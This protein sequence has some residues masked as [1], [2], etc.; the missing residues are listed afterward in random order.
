[1]V[2]NPAHYQDGLSMILWFLNARPVTIPVYV[3]HR[4]EATAPLV[5]TSGARDA[6]RIDRILQWRNGIWLLT[7]G[8]AEGDPNSTTERYLASTAAV[9]RTQ[10]LD[11]GYRA[12]HFAKLLP[13]TSG[14]E[15][16]TELGG[17][18][19]LDRWQIGSRTPAG[20]QPGSI[21]VSLRW[22][23]LKPV[24]EPLHTF[25]QAWD[26]RGKVLAQWSGVPSAGFAPA[27][28][29]Q[30]DQPVK[31]QIALMLPP[32]W[33]PGPIDVVVGMYDS[34]SGERL[35]TPDGEDVLRLDRLEGL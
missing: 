29:W 14:G 8:A 28:S 35:R 20:D 34:E 2:L 24:Q 22:R 16:R 18:V 1:L 3:V 33:A 32:D 13:A 17:L 4:E 9:E 5:G 25:V 7:Q 15:P 11:G 12:T 19:S 26:A 6:Y 10:W 27:P 30:P 23:P 21:Q 31:E